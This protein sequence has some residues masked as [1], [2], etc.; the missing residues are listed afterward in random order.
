MSGG[1]RMRTAALVIAVALGCAGPALAQSTKSHGLSIFGELKY[2]PG[3]QHFEY[4]NPDAPKGGTARLG[5]ASS[6]DNLNPL[7]VKG[8]DLR[9]MGG[10]AMVLG[11]ES[12]MVSAQDEPD[13]LYGL[14]AET[15]ELAEDRAWAV[16]T[17][18][19]E[20]RWHDG[21]PITA[22]DVVFSFETL[23][24]EGEPFYRLA[25]RDIDA[26][27]AVA[28]D[29]VKFTFAPGAS[30]DLP[31]L[32]AGM[33]ILS[34]AYYTENAFNQ[35]TLEPPLGSGPYR[36][37][38][39]DAG[40]SLTYERVGDYW[41]RDLA[42]NRGRYNFDT[43]RF[44]F[45]R[46]RTIEFEAF[47]A[48]EYDFREEFTSKTWATGYDAPAVHD[49]R[50]KRETLPD[51]SPSGTQAFFLNARLP[52]FS[53]RRVRLA[54]DYAFDFEWTNENL[55][56][57]L[58]ERTTSM[59]ENSDLRARGP[60]SEDERAL[61][62]PYRDVLPAEVFGAAYV[63]PVTDGSGRIRDHLMRARELLEQAAW[64][65]VDGRLVNA[66]G[67]QMSIEFMIDTP[68]F[69]RIIAPYVAN[70]KR[71]GIDAS[72]RLVD[73]AQFMSRVQTYDYDVMISRFTMRRTPGVEQRNFWSSAAADSPGGNNLAG[74]RNPAVDALIERLGTAQSRAELKSIVGALDRVLT[75]N[76]YSV[77]QWFKASH[78]IAYWD[79]FGRP[80]TKAR[81]ALGFLD[82]WWVDPAKQAA[83]EAARGQTAE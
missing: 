78:F 27:E 74:V 30:R 4:V 39:V 36:F 76:H 53:D 25:Y 73:S 1:V 13:S 35:T 40:R 67:E 60:L 66:E 54:L 75:W 3:F 37:G 65:V 18:R 77:P 43:I 57:G 81:F 19:P 49:G 17:L 5:Y 80:E 21:S 12:L 59:F 48:G 55:F 28:A 79:K 56:F 22:D 44:D 38:R 58:Y 15:I 50:I 7:I 24:T 31:N 29:Q 51:E 34:Q 26:V 11:V 52:K 47:K 8:I 46:D 72:I 16:F 9:G 70:L 61:L 6:F 71:L 23:T 42:V 20:A 32:A 63:P 45:Y 68:L 14:I 62:E 64:E 83:L 2:E 82:T 33:P 69:E 41:G 10:S